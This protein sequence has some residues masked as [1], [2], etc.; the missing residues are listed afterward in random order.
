[1]ALVI[2]RAGIARG[3]HAG[4][5][6]GLLVAGLAG[7]GRGALAEAA[8]EY[9]VKAA[10]LYY[11]ATFV[12]WPEEAFARRGDDLVI[13]VLGDDPFG[14]L[15]EETVRGKTA[16]NRRLVV[17]RFTRVKDALGSHILFVSA[18]EQERL[19]LIFKA[20][21]GTTILTIGDVEGF[22]ERGGQIGLRTEGTRVRFQINVAAAD[23]AGLRISSQLLKLGAP[24]PAMASPGG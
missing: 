21:E 14:P 13:G 24:V 1:M 10:Y 16:H 22:A 4:L 18:S 6:A 20:L 11:F 8:S 19:P 7:A 2:S 9:R 12:E 17:R 23:R 15:I 3:L 5:V